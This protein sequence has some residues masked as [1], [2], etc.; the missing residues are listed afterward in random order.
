MSTSEKPKKPFEVM[1]AKMYA[2]WNYNSTY[3]ECPICKEHLVSICIECISNSK[4]D[5]NSC[6]SS[7]AKC[8]HIFHKHCIDKYISKQKFSSLCPICQTPYNTE[9]ENLNN[10]KDW[11]KLANVS[12]AKPK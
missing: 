5:V 11:I 10:N 7:K 1:S 2:T 3:T 9:V 6:Y 12:K 8:G 4:T